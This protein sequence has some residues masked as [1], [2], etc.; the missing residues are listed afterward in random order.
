VPSPAT[1]APSRGAPP[2]ISTTT[3]VPQELHRTVRSPC[4]GVSDAPHFG[5]VRALV[6]IG[7]VSTGPP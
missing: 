5:Q 7:D 3:L 1:G 4:G 6:L 2:S